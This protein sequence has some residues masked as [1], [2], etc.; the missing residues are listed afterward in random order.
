[1]VIEVLLQAA[2]AGMEHAA[3]NPTLHV[4]NFNCII[5]TR[6][7]TAIYLEIVHLGH[8]IIIKERTYEVS[9]AILRLMAGRE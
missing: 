1:M 4:T 8:V 6:L 7:E 3:T 2:M 9:P 5:T